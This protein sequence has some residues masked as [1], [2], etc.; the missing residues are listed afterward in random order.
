MDTVKDTNEFQNKT[1]HELGSIAQQSE[2]AV[3]QQEQTNKTL[4]SLADS[5][6]SA[7]K[8]L[9]ALLESSNSTNKSLSS[10]NE[11]VQLMHKDLSEASNKKLQPTPKSGAAEH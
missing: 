2:R 10:I 8:K 6:D 3:V 11:G 7:N 1:I 5:S 4:T 9:D